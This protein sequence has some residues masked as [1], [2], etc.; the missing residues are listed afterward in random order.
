[1]SFESYMCMR[2]HL[3]HEQVTPNGVTCSAVIENCQWLSI[4]S[5]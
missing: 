5:L 3:I 1:M 2:L 4:V